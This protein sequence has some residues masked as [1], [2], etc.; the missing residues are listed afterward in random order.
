[1]NMEVVNTLKA[2]G[3]MGSSIIIAGH[4]TR[5]SLF[6]IAHLMCL[7]LLFHLLLSKKKRKIPIRND[8][9]KCLRYF[10]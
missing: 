4:S 9:S 7:Y 5:W 2:S 10:I 6:I 1:M 8:A 3:K